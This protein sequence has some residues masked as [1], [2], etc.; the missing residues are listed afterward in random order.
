MKAKTFADRVADLRRS[1]VMFPNNDYP[2]QS[3]GKQLLT[4][5][6][7]EMDYH[8]FA[9]HVYYAMSATDRGLIVFPAMGM[10]LLAPPRAWAADMQALYAEER[11]RPLR[12]EWVDDPRQVPG[13]RLRLGT[14]RYDTVEVGYLNVERAKGLQPACAR[15]VAELDARFGPAP[16]FSVIVSN[17]PYAGLR[18][19]G[20]G[21]MLYDAALRELVARHGPVNLVPH[22]CTWGDTSAEA[23]RVWASLRKRYPSA[24]LAIRAGAA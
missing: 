3:Y 20:W 12:V 22:A 7:Q 1:P 19:K 8:R 21:R 4:V 17:I 18:A 23:N 6:A 9:A 11:A 2:H 13:V 24:G 15:D 14:G 16:T 5:L 10:G